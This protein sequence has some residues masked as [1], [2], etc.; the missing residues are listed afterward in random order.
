MTASRNVIYPV[1][2]TRLAV[3]LFDGCQY[4]CTYCPV[5]GIIHRPANRFHEH[6]SARHNI[7]ER[8]RKE[9]YALEDQNESREIVLSCF[10]DPYHGKKSLLSITSSVIEILA[11]S[12]LHFTTVSRAGDLSLRDL[13]IIS[14]HNAGSRY[15]YGV[16]MCT[17]DSRL[18]KELEPHAAT[19]EARI[20][21]LRYVRDKYGFRTWVWITPLCKELPW[22]HV[23]NLTDTVTEYASSIV[24]GGENL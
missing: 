13:G 24:I 7:I 1:G 19:P 20:T 17:L 23:R 6:V 15:R 12:N 21:N 10:S 8:V 3:N 16:S 2:K 18:S 4:G 22:D 11:E 5:P 14:K 9:V